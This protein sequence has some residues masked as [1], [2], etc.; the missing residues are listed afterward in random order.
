MTQI[1]SVSLERPLAELADEL[2]RSFAEYGFAIVRD[3]GIPG[4]LIAR[5]EA[6]SRE[7]F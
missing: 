5:D 4:D 1:A 3:H 6:I 2:G 7:F